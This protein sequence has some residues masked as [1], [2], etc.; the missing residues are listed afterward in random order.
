M[1]Y[2]RNNKVFY[3]FFLTLYPPKI[4]SIKHNGLN[5]HFNERVCKRGDVYLD[6]T[7]VKIL[8]KK[9]YLAAPGLSCSTQI[10]D[11]CCS[12]VGSLV[13]ACRLLVVACGI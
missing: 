3:F 11:L 10:F 4:P 12:H 2:L 9:N 6:C 13:V 5:F 8:I 7:H 1:T